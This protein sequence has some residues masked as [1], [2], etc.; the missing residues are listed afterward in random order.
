MRVRDG[1][2]REASPLAAQVAGVVSACGVAQGQHDLA[3]L[4]ALQSLGP[5]GCAKPVFLD[6]GAVPDL[7]EVAPF[8][9]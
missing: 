8:K 2:D 7:R 4:P 1:L 3:V 6:L 5:V 9:R